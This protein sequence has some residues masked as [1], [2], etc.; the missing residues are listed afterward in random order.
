MKT[1]T[2]SDQSWHYR[3]ARFAD[4]HH[5]R[6]L[7]D[8]CGYTRAVLSGLWW[9]VMCTTL[10][11]L[12]LTSTGDLLTWFVVGIT[13]N[14]VELNAQALMACIVWGVLAGLF[15]WAGIHILVDEWRKKREQVDVPKSEPSF[16][17]E[18]YDA[19]KNKY[20]FKVEIIKEKKNESQ[21]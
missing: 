11:G 20:C 17:S 8:I 15:A 2:F 6:K 21:S 14:F 4:E 12:L 3:L 7:D 10:A 18:A 1:A 19:F 5:E 16:V 9:F 13:I